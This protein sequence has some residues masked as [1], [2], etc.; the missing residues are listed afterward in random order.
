MRKKIR[1]GKTYL[2]GTSILLKKRRKIS[3][4]NLIKKV[5]SSGSLRLL[6]EYRTTLRRT[7]VASSSGTL[8]LLFDSASGK[9]RSVREALPKPSRRS[10]K[11]VSTV[12]R[13][14]LEAE[15][16]VS[17]RAGEAL[18]SS[19]FCL[20]NFAP[21]SAF[22]AIGIEFSSGSHRA[23][24]IKTRCRL[25]EN[26]MKCKKSAGIAQKMVE[27]FQQVGES[28]LTYGVEPERSV[29]RFFK[30][31]CKA[32]VFRANTLLGSIGLVAQRALKCF[33]FV[34]DYKPAYRMILICLI[35]CLVSMFSLS[36]QTPRKDSG[37]DGLSS[38][39]ALKPGDKIPDAVW[40]Q[41]LELNYFNGKKKTIKFADLKGKLI[42]LDFW[43]T[44]CP[45]CIE[46]FPHLEDVLAIN[47]DEIAVLLVN[48]TQTKDTQKRVQDLKK[49]YKTAY[50]FQTSLPYLFGDTI[51]QQLFPHNAVPHVVWINKD[52][53]LVANTYPNALSK[54][55]ITAVLHTGNADFHQKKM[56]TNKEVALITN[57]M[58]NNGF[59][60]GSVFQTYQEGL[61]A[62]SGNYSFDGKRTRYQLLNLRFSQLV[63][64]AFQKELKGIP[65]RH[66]QFAASSGVNPKQRLLTPNRYENSFCYEMV[67]LDSLPKSRAKQFFTEDFKKFFGIKLSVENKPTDVW[68]VSFNSAA[69]KVRSKGGVPEVFLGDSRTEMKFRNIPLELL[70]DNLS[71][72]FHRPLVIGASK[73]VLVDMTIPKDFE[74]WEEDTR[75]AF[76]RAMGLELNSAQETI[77]CAS[78]S[79]TDR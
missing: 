47:K 66:W 61:D 46:G 44:W 23:T 13:R 30:S 52:G 41:S 69:E 21:A 70:V 2:K 38:L 73:E 51:F 45:S 36:A 33:L 57:E 59:Y 15:P 25:D 67:V 32:L 8:R 24:P 4:Q 37:A 53:I 79:L 19:D 48:S 39:V 16:K 64:L 77:A 58:L 10:A 56:R 40:N 76:L 17:R 49:K 18:P 3:A 71:L 9:S 62:S 75:K 42:L 14:S 54:E 22:H 68:R 12:S 43:A 34:A 28:R 1:Q 11:P 7:S 78:F 50:G 65:W 74:G 20:I 31:I 27:D 29:L 63:A 26:P 60:A 55:N 72:Y 35:L 5:D 6:F